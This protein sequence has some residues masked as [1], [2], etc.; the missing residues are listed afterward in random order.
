MSYKQSSILCSL[1][2]MFLI[3]HPPPPHIHIHPPS[4][5]LMYDMLEC[6]SE[7]STFWSD[8][9]IELNM[10]Q[11]QNSNFKER[12]SVES[13]VF[14]SHCGTSIVPGKKKKEN[15]HKMTFIIFLFQWKILIKENVTLERKWYLGLFSSATP[16]F[17]LLLLSSS[18][19]EIWQIMYKFKVYDLMIWYVYIVKWLSQ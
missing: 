19:I 10:E 6:W 3:S 7:K 18:F 15:I 5:L 17:C 1:F 12:S 11:G 16:L 14:F 2:Q 9:E 13:K 4:N 8:K